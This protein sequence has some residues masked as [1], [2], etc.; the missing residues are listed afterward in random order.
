MGGR[1]REGKERGREKRGGRDRENEKG[2]MRIF[3]FIQFKTFTKC[4]SIFRFLFNIHFLGIVK[5][6][7]LTLKI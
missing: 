1:G 4:S 6:S 7:Y 3:F 5:I 2:K